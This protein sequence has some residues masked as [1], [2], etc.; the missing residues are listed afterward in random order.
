MWNRLKFGLNKRLSIPL[1]MLVRHNS[2]NKKLITLSAF[3]ENKNKSRDAFLEMLIFFDDKRNPQR[4]NHVDF[5][6]KALKHMKEYGV[7]KDLEVYKLMIN[8]LPKG[9]LTIVF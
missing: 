6:Y 8:L 1:A 3:E 2:R 4:R 7:E 9:L 5:I